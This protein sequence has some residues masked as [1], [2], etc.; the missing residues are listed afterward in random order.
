VNDPEPTPTAV[1][2][3]GSRGIGLASARALAEQGF[4]VAIVGRRQDSIDQAIA[5]LNEQGHPG[6]EGWAA[7]ATDGVQLARAFEAIEGRCDYLNVLVNSVGPSVVGT[8]DALEEDDWM[9]AFSQG[10]LSAVRAI[11]L[12]LPMMRRAPWARIVNVTAMSTQHQTPNLIAYTASKAALTSITKN[13]ARHLAADGILVNAVAPGSVMTG[14][15]AAAVCAAG[16]DPTDA[17]A[18]Y[19]VMAD[20]FGAHIDLERVAD[21]DEIAQVVAFCASKANSFMTGAHLNV[22]GGSDFT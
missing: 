11:K 6:V 13:L 18:S 2:C 15:V 10:S 14:G 21:P 1:V 20:L 3:G 5:G 4:R 16:G 17:E 7:D 9:R 19:A 8:F 22:D 12:A